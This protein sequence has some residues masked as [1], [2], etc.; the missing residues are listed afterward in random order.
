[1]DVFS[2]PG[3]T[4]SKMHNS[5]GISV[6]HGRTVIESAEGC[7][8]GR[9]TKCPLVSEKSEIMRFY[10]NSWYNNRYKK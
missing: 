9:C 4:G 10:R 5:P 7:K 8:K 1:M 3:C 6:A 2:G